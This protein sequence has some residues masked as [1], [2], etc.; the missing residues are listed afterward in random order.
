M[1]DPVTKVFKNFTTE[2]G[3]QAEQF[4]QH[5]SLKEQGPGRLYFG[6]VNGF[7]SFSPDQ[8]LD[9]PY[10]PSLVLTKFQVFN[11]EVEVSRNDDDPSPLK[12]DISETKAIRLSHDQSVIS[13]E[14]AALDYTSP[15][16]KKYA[17]ILEGFDKN[18]N[19]VRG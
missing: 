6:G 15:N 14:Y 12:A 1:F 7:N 16:K 4:L 10:N 11:K 5:C 2:N 3:L 8:I 18:W 13:F 17:Y 9:N 19:Y